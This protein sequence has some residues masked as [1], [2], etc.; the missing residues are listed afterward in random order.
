MEH[1][2][3]AKSFLKWAGSK[4]KLLP[5]LR[6]YWKP[7]Q[8][9]RYIEPFVG[10]AQLFFT[11]Q[12]QSA[13]LNDI[14]SELINTYEIVR[15]N[16]IELFDIM[17]TYPKDKDFYYNIRSADLLT[18]SRLEKAARFIYLN[19]LCFN[20][21]YRTNLKGKFN[22]PYSNSPT[23]GFPTKDELILCSKALEKVLLVNSDFETVLKDNCQR[24]D[25][26][27]LDPPYAIANSNIFYQYDPRT[28]GLEDVKRLK[29][30]LVELDKNN[31]DFLL[32]YAYCDEIISLFSEWNI[33]TVKTQRN[34]AGFSKNRKKAIE[35]LISNCYEGD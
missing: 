3:S 5:E 22:V 25:F 35:L 13:I 9:Q 16:P 4:K 17:S 11:L 18:L 23:S 15:N 7:G 30:I 12:P 8:H 20:G 10:S 31:I 28:F 14:N 33:R 19:K 34:I 2:I 27:Y 6:N 29:S 1:P 24:G 26:V 21:L 32:S